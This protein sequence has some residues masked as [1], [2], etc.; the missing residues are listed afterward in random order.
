MNMKYERLKHADDNSFRP[1]QEIAHQNSV[2]LQAIQG[3]M[4][5]LMNAV[6]KMGTRTTTSQEIIDLVSAGGDII[7]FQTQQLN[8]PN[9]W[10]ASGFQSQVASPTPL[11]VAIR[12]HHQP[13]QTTIVGATPQGR[14]RGKQKPVVPL[15]PEDQNVELPVKFNTV[16]E[17]LEYWTDGN[18]ALNVLP[19]KDWSSRARN[20]PKIKSRYS[21]VKAIAQHWEMIQQFEINTHLQNHFKLAPYTTARKLVYEYKK[22][23]SKNYSTMIHLLNQLAY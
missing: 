9:I 16:E 5:Q 10:K 18:R 20:Q 1:V 2:A 15:L 12:P 7:E 22:I 11:H 13:I 8:P 19:M 4:I 14:R 6:D 21:Q 3:M 23:E 17:A